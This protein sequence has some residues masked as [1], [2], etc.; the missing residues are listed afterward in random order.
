MTETPKKYCGNC[1]DR[2]SR[3]ASR[4]PY[5]GKRI[6]TTRLVATCVLLVAIV[7]ALFFLLLD[8]QNIEFF[9]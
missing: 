9:K 6:I 5:C 1:G 3:R 7:V 8:Y 4:C 2:I